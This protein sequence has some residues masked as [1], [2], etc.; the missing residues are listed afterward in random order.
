M[1]ERTINVLL[2]DD[3]EDDCV[4][5]RDLLS[6]IP[7]AAYDVKCATTYDQALEELEKGGH[8]VCLLDYRLGERDGLELLYDSA[9]KGYSAPIIF[10]TGQGNLEV[11][12]EAMR[13]GAADFLT[14]GEITGS[15]LE[16][17]IRHAMERRRI[18]ENLRESENQCRVLSSQLL[19]A[20]ETE[21]RN[22]AGEIHDSIGQTL[23]VIKHATDKALERIR[24]GD[25]AEADAAL[26]TVLAMVRNASQE[27]RR[28]QM[29]LRP[30]MLDDLGL[31]ATIN[32]FG[33]EFQ[34]V[35]SGIQIERRIATEED[36]IPQTLKIN[37]YRII[38]EAFNNIA[39]HSGADR[40]VLSLQTVCGG[41]ALTIQDNGRGFELE[42]T[43][44]RYRKGMGLTS[45]RERAELSGGTFSIQSAMGKG[46]TL[47]FTWPGP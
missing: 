13:A 29:D 22:L 8:D 40:V 6:E 28:M 34:K 39:R 14:K 3:D 4:L 23:T 44:R 45:M 16:R 35:Y 38:Q 19:T 32:W 2:V 24:S 21:R 17:S 43:R 20:Q 10:L 30:P 41:V 1:N 9:G 42:E 11:D 31:L 12:M 5:V 26:E 36:E 25:A 37:L 15:L 47:S 46:T 18:M 33:R 7:H 27:A